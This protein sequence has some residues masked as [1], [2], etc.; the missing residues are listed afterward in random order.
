MTEYKAGD[1]VIVVDPTSP[2]FMDEVVEVVQYSNDMVQ[3]KI[4]RQ[5]EHYEIGR[6]FWWNLGRVRLYNDTTSCRKCKHACK[7]DE[8]CPLYEEEE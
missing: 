4:L 6:T 7:L 2:Y 1:L 3:I 8:R 5:V